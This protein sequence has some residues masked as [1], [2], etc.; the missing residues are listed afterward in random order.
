V[1]VSKHVGRRYRGGHPRSYLNV[2]ISSDLADESHWAGLFTAGVTTAY[3]A[4]STAMLG[5][6]SGSTT[7]DGEVTVSYVDK[8][9]NPV[10][11]FRRPTPLVLPVLAAT[12][13]TQIAVQRRRIG[14]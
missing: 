9:V 3:A 4:L 5:H 1:L 7:L 12:A 13:Q 10:A 6:T 8:A 11:P 14:R 2:G